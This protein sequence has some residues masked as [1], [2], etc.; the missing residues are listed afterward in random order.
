MQIH[1]VVDN[2]ALEIILD[3]IDDD[4]LAHVHELEVCVFI[5]V[6]VGIES[7]VNFLVHLDSF[8][9]VLGC[10]FGILTLVVRACGLNVTDI[11]HDELLVVA[12]AL[13]KEDLDSMSSAGLH[14]P[15]AAVLCGIG[16]IEDADN[17]SSREPGKHVGDGSLGSL[18]AFPLAFCV[19]H[20][21][22][23][24]SWLRSIIAAVIADIEDLR[25]NRQPL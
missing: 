12:F 6:A 21:E 10:L 3:A 18:T 22:K 11:G 2:A 14:H 23:V 1:E 20:I 15:L 17:A 19:V 9:E 4:L 8:A 13:H 25:G 7:L 24:R 16:S 5:L